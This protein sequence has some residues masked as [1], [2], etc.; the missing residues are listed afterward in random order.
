MFHAHEIRIRNWFRLV[1]RHHAV[2]AA[3]W[4]RWTSWRTT[5]CLHVASYGTG[6][7]AVYSYAA[8]GRGL[9]LGQPLLLPEF[10]TSIL[11]PYL[12]LQ[13]TDFEDFFLDERQM[14]ERGN[15]G[16]FDAST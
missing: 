6:S 4:R 1:R 16:W 9:L 14:Y 5:F 10:R 3:W 2:R 15:V 13:D 11:E 7:S 12:Q 8:L